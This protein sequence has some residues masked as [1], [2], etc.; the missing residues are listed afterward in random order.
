[1]HQLF[2]IFCP[3]LPH[4]FFASFVAYLQTKRMTPECFKLVDLLQWK[5][6]NCDCV[7]VSQTTGIVDVNFAG[8]NDMEKKIVKN[9]MCL[10]ISCSLLGVFKEEIVTFLQRK[11]RVLIASIGTSM[12]ALKAFLCCNFLSWFYCWS[13]LL[14]WFIEPVQ[15][16]WSFSQKLQSYCYNSAQCGFGSEGALDIL[17]GVLVFWDETWF[18]LK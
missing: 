11:R 17:C 10:T 13:C 1:M 12:Y 14:L 2:R 16:T 7:C 6:D 18:L 3:C 8:H 4:V 15:H 9:V 5:C